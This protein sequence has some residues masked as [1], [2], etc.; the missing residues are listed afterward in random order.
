MRVDTI[1]HKEFNLIRI[2]RKIC[3]TDNENDDLPGVDISFE[4]AL[5]NLKLEKERRRIKIK[6]LEEQINNEHISREQKNR[7]MQV[8]NEHDEWKNLIDNALEEIE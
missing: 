1:P 8:K 7:L 5:E 3:Q 4:E 2:V 6:K